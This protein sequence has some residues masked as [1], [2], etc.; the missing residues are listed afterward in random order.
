MTFRIGSFYAPACPYVGEVGDNVSMR[1][2]ISSDIQEETQRHDVVEFVR[3]IVRYTV[4]RGDV[5]LK[6]PP[7][8]CGKIEKSNVDLIKETNIKLEYIC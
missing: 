7:A 2:L 8:T 4:T 1:L 6:G 3:P 5:F